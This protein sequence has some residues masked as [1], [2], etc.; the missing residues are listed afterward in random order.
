VIT[1]SLDG[2]QFTPL[3]LPP[4]TL[5]IGEHIVPAL[6][7]KDGQITLKIL[8]NKAVSALLVLSEFEYDSKGGGPQGTEGLAG[9]PDC[10]SLS[11]YPCPTSNALVMEYAVPIAGVVHITLYDAVGR[12]VQEISNAYMQ[13]GMY[14]KQIGLTGIAQ[15][16]YFLRLESDNEVIT[17]KTIVLR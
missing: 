1:F 15:G 5:I 17:R 9:M 13:P 6:L 16:V 14:Q 7:Y 2:H 11:A 12:C 10:L 8:G 4:D 3:N